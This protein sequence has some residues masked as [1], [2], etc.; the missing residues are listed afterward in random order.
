MN[1]EENHRR[2]ENQ[3]L[4]LELFVRMICAGNVARM[5][6]IT[7]WILLGK[8]KANIYLEAVG[9]RGETYV[10]RVLKII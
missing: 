6:R 8:P 5:G 10:K 1:T 3:G 4:L 9:V 7:Y 2:K